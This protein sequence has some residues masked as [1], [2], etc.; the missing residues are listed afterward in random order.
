LSDSLAVTFIRS[1]LQVI[2]VPSPTIP[3]ATT[4]NAWLL[5]NKNPIIVDPA[6]RG[7]HERE[8][9]VRTMASNPPSAIF[10]THHHHDHIGSATH[11]RS[12][13]NIPILAHEKTNKI[14]PFSIDQEIKENDILQ[15]DTEEWLAIHTPGHAPGHLCLLSQKDQTVVAGDMVAGEGT[16]LINPKEGSIREYL[17]SL[18]KLRTL[19]PSK[20]L[21]AHGP[22]LNNAEKTLCHYIS[23]RQHRL[24]QIRET[25]KVGPLSE[26][27][28]AREM[29]T[30]I[31]DVLLPAAAIQV[32]CGL[33]W[34]QEEGIV[35][36]ENNHWI[37]A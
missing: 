32:Y 18:E 13:F 22:I 7:P 27:E 35:L 4:T 21:P 37:L 17:S 3:P 6:A 26:A 30:N 2:E 31:P 9:I 11:L 15:S 5:G 25:L 14:L 19:N 34:L 20:L 23:H 33:I 1:G 28:I 29:Y 16:I 12:H 36:Q 10:L 24:E 8:E